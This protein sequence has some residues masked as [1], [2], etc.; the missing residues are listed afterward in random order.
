MHKIAS[1]MTYLPSASVFRS[2]DCVLISADLIY[3]VATLDA[4]GCSESLGLEI[5]L[6][7]RGSIGCGLLLTKD[8][9]RVEPFLMMNTPMLLLIPVCWEVLAFSSDEDVV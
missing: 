4:N 5:W 2:I 9:S 6:P 7:P 8:L 3:V 1:V